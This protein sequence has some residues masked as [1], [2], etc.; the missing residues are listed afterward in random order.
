MEDYIMYVFYG[1]RGPESVIEYCYS[2]VVHVKE[3][4]GVAEKALTKECLLNLGYEF[5]GEIKDTSELPFFLKAWKSKEVGSEITI[6]LEKVEPVAPKVD[7]A[8]LPKVDV[9]PLPNSDPMSHQLP[10]A[11][12]GGKQWWQ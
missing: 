10:D 1:K 6:P 9:A 7:V 2:E 3:R 8:P 12:A 11:E 4:I 5:L